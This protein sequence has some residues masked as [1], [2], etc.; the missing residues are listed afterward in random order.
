MV[1]E[2]IPRL[3]AAAFRSPDASG[4]PLGMTSGTGIGFVSYFWVVGGWRDDGLGSFRI[5]W[6]SGT[7][8]VRE[9]GSFRVFGENP[10]VRRG[11]HAFG[12]R[13]I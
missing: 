11:R 4:L 6:G 7:V 3:W 8:G 5:F 1:I 10:E 2:R 12:A 9:L 13:S